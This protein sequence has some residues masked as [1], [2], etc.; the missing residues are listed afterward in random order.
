MHHQFPPTTTHAAPTGPAQPSSVTAALMAGTHGRLLVR[1][2]AWL[3]LAGRNGGGAT[4]ALLD[5]ARQYAGGLFWFVTDSTAYVYSW[6]F[7]AL[8]IG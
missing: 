2:D 6:F 7:L 3:L 5:L 8:C 1:V 4:A